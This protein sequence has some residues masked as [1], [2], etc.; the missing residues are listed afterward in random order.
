MYVY[1]IEYT[2]I[3]VALEASHCHYS[4]KINCWY[5]K[6]WSPVVLS[7]RAI[8][9]QLILFSIDIFIFFL[10]K[11][12]MYGALWLLI[13]LFKQNHA[14]KFVVVLYNFFYWKT[15]KK[16][17]QNLQ[18]IH[19]YKKIHMMIWFYYGIHRLDRFISLLAISLCFVFTRKCSLYDTTSSRTFP[20]LCV[21]RQTEGSDR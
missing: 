13:Y 11:M 15:K 8:W 1:G 3:A 6:T 4:N 14:M 12:C 5:I 19:L 17:P 18:I 7:V 21:Y 10:M 9:W 20:K 2:V 16:I